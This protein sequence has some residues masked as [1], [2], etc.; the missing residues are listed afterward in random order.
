MSLVRPLITFDATGQIKNILKFQAFGIPR[1]L[2]MFY[3]DRLDQS[4]WRKGWGGGGGPQTLILQSCL[5]YH[6]SAA[7]D[8]SFESTLFLLDSACDT[9]RTTA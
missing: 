8:L 1:I 2:K 4:Y 3:F 6:N 5:F 9:C 7:T